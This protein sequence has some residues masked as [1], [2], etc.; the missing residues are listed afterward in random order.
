MIFDSTLTEYPAPTA[1]IIRTIADDLGEDDNS[2]PNSTQSLSVEQTVYDEKIEFST[3]F[4]DD[5]RVVFSLPEPSPSYFL[6]KQL[7]RLERTPVEGRWKGATWPRKKAFE[8]AKNFAA[9]LPLTQIPRPELYLADDGEVNFFWSDQGMHVDLGFYGTGTY[10]CFARNSAGRR[11]V[12]EE[13]K[14]TN[15]LP[16]DLLNLFLS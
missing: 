2:P 6:L 16:D 8:D 15:G 5:G 14:A 9:K 13:A 11:F 7:M 1:G 12:C 10:S 4:L 3:Y